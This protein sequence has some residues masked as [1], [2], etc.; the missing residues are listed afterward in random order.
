MHKWMRVIGMMLPLVGTAA[1]ADLQAQAENPACGLLTEADLK[2]ATGR[3][4]DAASPGDA[5]G[6]GAGGGASCQW[7]DPA[8]QDLPMVSVVFIPTKGKKSYT[9]VSRAFKAQPGCTRE[10]APGVGSDAFVETCPR[11][12]GPVVYFRKGAN[13]G[14][15]Q[16]DVIKS[17]SP[18]SVKQT[19]VALAKAVVGH[20]P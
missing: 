20:M 10:P 1:V 14:I 15:V 19:A 16:V 3:D 11:D 9:E 7:G 13:D 6:E 5:M 4:Y 12:R 18:A 17:A 8:G 2:Q